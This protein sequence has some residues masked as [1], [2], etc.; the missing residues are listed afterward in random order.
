MDMMEL[1][2]RADA[3]PSMGGYTL[4][5]YL[6]EAAAAVRPGRAIVEVGAWLGSGTAQLCIGVIKS[7]SRAPIYCFDRWTASGSEVRKAGDAGIKI[8]GND[9][10]LP[11]IRAN[12]EPFGCE[13]HYWRGDIR[14][15]PWQGQRIG[16]YIDDAAKRKDKFLH[17]MQTFGPSF[18]PG[19]TMLILMDYYYYEHRTG[20]AG[21]MF[22]QEY[23]DHHKEFKFMRRLNN[24]VAAMFKYRGK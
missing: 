13:I 1:Q 15:A 20:D 19:E 17:V 7:G 14:K 4:R 12:L 18:I 24:S 2:A 8:K 11:H 9:D 5:A 16:L 22:Q 23:M 6:Q 3:I 21:L 10:L